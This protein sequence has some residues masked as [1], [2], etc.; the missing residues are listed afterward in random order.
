MVT[1]EDQQVAPQSRMALEQL[2]QGIVLVG[3]LASVECLH[4][5]GIRDLAAPGGHLDLTPAAGVGR[6]KGVFPVLWLVHRVVGRRGSIGTVR[7]EQVQPHEQ[8]PAVS[9]PVLQPLFEDGNGLRGV[10]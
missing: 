9:R 7:I 2:T 3:D 4:V 6:I 10:S 5:A 1:D 8:R